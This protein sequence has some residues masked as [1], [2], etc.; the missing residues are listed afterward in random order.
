MDK[1][2]IEE[3]SYMMCIVVSAGWRRKRVPYEEFQ[4]VSPYD[5]DYKADYLFIK[6]QKIHKINGSPNF[7]SDKDEIETTFFSLQDAF[8]EEDL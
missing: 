2:E 4:E 7:M 5:E 8:Y 3:I 6:D 1:K